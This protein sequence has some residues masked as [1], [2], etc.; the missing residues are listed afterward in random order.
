[1]KRPLIQIL[2]LILISF[3]STAAQRSSSTKS[4]QTNPD[5]IQNAAIV[6]DERLAVLLT[7]PSLYAVPI[8]R[9]R[10]GRQLRVLSSKD[11]DGVT[12]YEVKTSETGD[13]KGWVQS[14]AIIGNFRRNDDQRLAK[15]VQASTGFAKIERTVFFLTYFPQSAL[16]PSILLLLGDLV[17]E[18]ALALSKKAAERLDRREMAASGAPLHSFYLSYLGLDRYRKL[19]IRFLFNINTKALHYDGGTWF[20]LIDKFP[21]SREADEARSRLDFLKEKM[22]RN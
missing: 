8:Q 1:M 6:V 7:D 16:R 11:A 9:L 14:E 22:E 3:A 12:F 21:K 5:E 18:E 15:L 19:G 2:A 10:R 4:D 17:E 13:R 20:E